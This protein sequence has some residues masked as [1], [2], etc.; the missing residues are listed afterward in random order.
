LA[1]GVHMDVFHRDLL[2]AFAAV[3]IERAQRMPACENAFRNL[4]LNQRVAAEAR[5]MDQAASRLLW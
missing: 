5:F 4:I 1:A 2:L 3:A